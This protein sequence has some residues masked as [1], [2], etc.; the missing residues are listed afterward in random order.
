[1]IAVGAGEHGDVLEHGLAAVAVARRLDG[2]DL[3]HGAAEL[4]DH[5]RGEGLAGDVLG[6]DE[7]RLL[8][9]HHLLEQRD[10]LLDA[11]D[12]VLVDEDEGLLEID[13]HLLGIGDEVRER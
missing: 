11:V 2:A 5:E 7:Q 13:L 1:M 8:G 4:V 6:D 10:E 9:L 3:Q 12:L